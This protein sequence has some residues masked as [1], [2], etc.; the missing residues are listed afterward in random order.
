[1]RV[2]EVNM[3]RR[4]N[5]GAGETGDRRENPPSGTIPTYENSV[6]RLVLNLVRLE[7]R[8]VIAA[9]RVLCSDKAALRHKISVCSN[10]F[11][12]RVV[13]KLKSRLRPFTIHPASFQ[14]DGLSAG[15]GRLRFMAWRHLSNPA[16]FIN[17]AAVF[18][19]SHG[20]WPHHEYSRL[21]PM[22]GA[23]H[24]NDIQTSLARHL[25]AIQPPQARR[26]AV[27]HRAA[28]G[29]RQQAGIIWPEFVGSLLPARFRYIGELLPTPIK[30]RITTRVVKP[31]INSR[32]VV[33]KKCL[34]EGKKVIKKNFKKQGDCTQVKALM[35]DDMKVAIACLALR[36]RLN[37]VTPVSFPSIKTNFPTYTSSATQQK[38]AF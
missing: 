12:S 18:Q 26:F 35:Y 31:A 17:S 28:S 21:S 10:V 27:I 25:A 33:L 22:C 19:T 20:S 15:A 38:S 1:M 23:W 6:T 36:T 34:F 13:E 16:W 37:T 30:K 32:G 4:R 8:L 5:E 11:K 24:C 3:D 2:I 14:L 29:T 7:S 9:R